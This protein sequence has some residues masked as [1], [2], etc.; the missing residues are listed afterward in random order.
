VQLGRRKVLASARSEER[1]KDKK[2]GI[3]K[4]VHVETSHHDRFRHSISPPF[5]GLPQPIS[6]LS[7]CSWERSM[8]AGSSIAALIGVF[9]VGQGLILHGIF[10]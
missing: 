9:V 6:R 10:R 2:S 3:R 8:S 1:G 7:V 4:K 5:Q